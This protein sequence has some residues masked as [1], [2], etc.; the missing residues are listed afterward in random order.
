V[1][2]LVAECIDLVEL[3]T[4]RQIRAKDGKL[5]AMTMTPMRLGHPDASGRRRPIEEP[6]GEFEIAID[7]L[8]VAIGQR[9]DLSFLDGNEVKLTQAGYLAVDPQSL[10]T[11][12]PGVFAGGD[13][14]GEG[15]ESIVKACGDGRRIADAINSRLRPQSRSLDDPPTKW[16]DYPI[17][18]LLRRRARLERRVE[19]PHLPAADRT[20]FAEVVLTLS[21][22]DAALEAARCLDC[23]LMCSTCDS[24]C[25]N[26]AIFTYHA[27][28]SILRIPRLHLDNGI[29]RIGSENSF[30]VEQGPQVAVL[31][32]LCN[33]CG[34]CVTFCPASGRPWFDKPRFFLNRLEFEAQSENA[35]M[36]IIDN[37]SSGIQARFEDQTHELLEVGSSLYYSSPS[38]RLEFDSKRMALQAAEAG[39]EPADGESVLVP[40]V[41]VMVTLLR[42]INSSMPEI[43]VVQADPSWLLRQPLTR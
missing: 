28:P 6:D 38:L 37:G 2:D 15:P 40:G 35:F 39:N 8:I 26:R 18:D 19:T 32:D 13:I 42:S 9:P 27:Q 5:A 33:E 12:L 23:D 43:P 25:P 1:H 31:T 7:T 4:P 21:P 36:L 14:I 10:E 29:L 34:N 30:R 24:V 41:G 16:P 22:E 3:T 11:S 17:A 20:D